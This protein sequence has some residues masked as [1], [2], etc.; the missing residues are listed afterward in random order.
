[1][2]ISSVVGSSAAASSA[3][4]P[5]NVKSAS[6]AEQSSQAKA[7]AAVVKAAVSAVVQEAKETPGQ[8]ISE[9]AGGDRQA[10]KRLDSGHAPATSGSVIDTKA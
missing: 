1:M 10:Q 3:V 8:T 9:A 6:A 7:T 5:A 4:V 2:S